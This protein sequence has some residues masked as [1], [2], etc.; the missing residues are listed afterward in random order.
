MIKTI[1]MI[2]QVL[3]LVLT[4]MMIK[5]HDLKIMMLNSDED[6]TMLLNHE[7]HNSKIRMLTQ[8]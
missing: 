6:I 8:R 3:F 1:M 7:E 2:M 5:Q 4:K